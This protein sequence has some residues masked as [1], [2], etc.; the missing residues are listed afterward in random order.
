MCGEWRI[1]SSSFKR[2]MFQQPTGGIGEF[3]VELKKILV[4][5]RNLMYNKLVK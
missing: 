5:L 2:T 4:N 3:L 1:E